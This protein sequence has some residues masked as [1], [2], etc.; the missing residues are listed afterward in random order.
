MV[1]FQAIC[2]RFA[3]YCL[4]KGISLP[5]KG[6]AV[7]YEINIPRQAG[8]SGSS[9]IACAT[10]NCLLQHY[11]V[12]DRCWPPLPPSTSHPCTHPH[13]SF[14]EGLAKQLQWIPTRFG[15]QDAPNCPLIPGFYL[16]QSTCMQIKTSLSCRVP[17]AER[18][19]LILSAEADLGIT[20]GLQ[21]RV[22]QV[23]CDQLLLS[24]PLCHRY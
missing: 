13:C 8:L 12:A 4:E 6:F 20:A 21:D 15:P 2:K 10:L 7:Q 1:C 9:A 3:E 14:F 22:I 17:L 16:S 19:Q 24:S 18:P 23:L 5:Q 11:D